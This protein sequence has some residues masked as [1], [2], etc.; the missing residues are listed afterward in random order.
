VQ[1]EVVLVFPTQ[2]DLDGSLLGTSGLEPFPHL[3][4]E[5]A[6]RAS[7]RRNALSSNRASETSDRPDGRPDQGA[8]LNLAPVLND[9]TFG[10]T[11]RQA[12]ACSDECSHEAR[13]RKRSWAANRRSRGL[14]CQPANKPAE[15]AGEDRPVASVV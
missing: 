2:A 4:A 13:A 7:A 1:I 15:A 14:R 5:R 8:A 6:A 3:G 12:Y 9:K 10:N 11:N